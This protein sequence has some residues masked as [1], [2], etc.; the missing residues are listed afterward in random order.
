MKKVVNFLKKGIDKG[1]YFLLSLQLAVY[2]VFSN[3]CSVLAKKT[4]TET[5]SAEDISEKI[6]T[7]ISWLQKILLVLAIGAVV[8]Y[9][10]LPHIIGGEEGAVK[11]RKALKAIIIGLIVGVLAAPLAGTVYSWF[12]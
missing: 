11:G 4:T 10:S 12:A 2:G 6:S 5:I 8:I 3:T 1:K 7:G 9:F